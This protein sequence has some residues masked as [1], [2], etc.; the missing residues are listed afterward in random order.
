MRRCAALTS[1]GILDVRGASPRDGHQH[2]HDVNRVA[3]RIQQREDDVAVDG[4]HAARLPQRGS[5]CAVDAATNSVWHSS[6]RGGTHPG[7]RPPPPPRCQRARKLRCRPARRCA[8]SSDS[9]HAVRRRLSPR[10]RRAALYL[11]RVGARWYMVSICFAVTFG[12]GRPRRTRSHF[13]VP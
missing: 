13:G 2:A 3:K 10:R 8:P 11:A 4:R 7:R 5:N 9:I 1:E 6:A 12:R